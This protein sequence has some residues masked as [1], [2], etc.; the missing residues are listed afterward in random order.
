M[1]ERAPSGRECR[2]HHFSRRRVDGVSSARGT[3]AAHSAVALAQPFGPAA[4]A[5]GRGAARASPP[6]GAPSTRSWAASGGA[7]CARAAP[8]PAAPPAGRARA[9]GC[10][11]ASARPARRR[12]RRGPQRAMM[13]AFCSSLSDARRGHVERRLDPRG[14]HVGVL[15]ARA[16]RAAGA[17]VDLVE[18]DHGPAGGVQGI[19]HG[20]DCGDADLKTAPGDADGFSVIPPRTL[21]DVFD[22]LA[23]VLARPRRRCSTSRP[24]AAPSSSATAASSGS[25]PTT[26]TTLEPAAYGHR[27]PERRAFA[28]REPARP[29]AARRRG[30]QRQG[31]R[32]PGRAT[33]HPGRAPRC[34]VSIAEPLRPY[35]ERYGVHSIVA[36]PMH[37]RGRVVGVMLVAR[38]AESEPLSEDDAET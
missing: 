1:V 28:E 9:R 21:A 3:D 34:R 15:A 37:A 10:A 13:R 30:H 24:R 38:E 35:L 26:A 31:R 5:L 18:A 11:P 22:E 36:A 12:A 29:A 17:Q 23:E 16:R 33:V 19:A 7:P 14:G 4:V 27:E 6:A 25:S 32:R 8:A 2:E 20:R